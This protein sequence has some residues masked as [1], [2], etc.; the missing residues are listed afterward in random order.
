MI[1]PKSPQEIKNEMMLDIFE[2]A[3]AELEA[4]TVTTTALELACWSKFRRRAIG[5]WDVEY[6]H[7]NLK[8]KMTEIWPV[9]RHKCEYFNNLVIWDM[10][11]GKRQEVRDI[12]SQINST[13]A[14]DSVTE[15]DNT[16]DDTVEVENNPE[17]VIATDTKYLAN[18]NTTRNVLD[19]VVTD[20]TD[21]VS[22]E[23]GSSTDTFIVTDTAGL[24]IE[25]ANKIYDN[26]RN[27]Y[28]DFAN[29]LDGLFM[30][31]W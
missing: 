3:I 12:S 1:L 2:T 30:N 9:Y 11:T 22:D 14:V 15:T 8:D 21:T 27:P 13:V 10:T 17:S 26:I 6:W 20:N 29:E 4:D 31:R 18:R 7:Q 28:R 24:G 5:D 16:V 23:I 19:G 25:I